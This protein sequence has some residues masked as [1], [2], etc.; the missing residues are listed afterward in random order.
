L[1]LIKKK[2]IQTNKS[3]KTT[4]PLETNFVRL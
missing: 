1:K 2:K 3:T 4:K